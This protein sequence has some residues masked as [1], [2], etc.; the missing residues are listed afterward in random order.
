MKFMGRTFGQTLSIFIDYRDAPCY[1]ECIVRSQGTDMMVTYRSN[2]KNRLFFLSAFLPYIILSFA[3]PF[4]HHHDHDGI[5]IDDCDTHNSAAF[6]LKAIPT[7]PI[8]SPSSNSH[9]D[10][11]HCIACEWENSSLSNAPHAVTISLTISVISPFIESRT[12][13]YH[14]DVTRTYSTRGPPQA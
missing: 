4:M 7:E 6:H 2:F 3:M 11:D 13:A 10:E 12:S 1:N 14:K 9:H 5:D 8:L